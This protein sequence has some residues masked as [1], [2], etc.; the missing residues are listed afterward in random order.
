M[1]KGRRLNLGGGEAMGDGEA[2]LEEGERGR[3]Y[4]EA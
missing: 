4:K 2:G 3:D 1:Y